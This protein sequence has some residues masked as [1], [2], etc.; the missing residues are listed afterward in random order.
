MSDVLKWALAGLGTFVGA[1]LIH[2]CGSFCYEQIKKAIEN[3]SATVDRSKATRELEEYKLLLAYH[4]GVK[5]R[6]G[7]YLLMA[8]AS[9]ASLIMSLGFL[10][11]CL[12]YLGAQMRNGGVNNIAALWDID[13]L[14]SLALLLSALVAYFFMVLSGIGF[15]RLTRQIKRLDEFR[16]YQADMRAKFPNAIEEG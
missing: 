11:A 15:E 12:I 9:I 6:Y 5:D 8:L 10:M 1:V 13:P 16:Q 2:M 3:V 4:K 7:G 14:S